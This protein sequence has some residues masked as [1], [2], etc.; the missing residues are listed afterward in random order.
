M[1]AAMQIVDGN[2]TTATATELLNFGYSQHSQAVE[3]GD[4]PTV[5]SLG[6]AS[7]VVYISVHWSDTGK[8]FLL[9]C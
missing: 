6:V 4:F 5:F 1:R 2:V 3:R 7:S 8:G 9:G